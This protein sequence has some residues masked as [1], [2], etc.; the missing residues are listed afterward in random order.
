MSGC[1]R[2]IVAVFAFFLI[3]LAGCGGASP[4]DGFTGDRGQVSGTITLDD[5]P[6]QEGCQVLFLAEQGGYMATGVVGDDG[7]Y[8][9]I[10]A[11]GKGLPVGDYKVQVA[12]PVVVDSSDADTTV[13][14]MEMASQM[15]L[16]PGAQ[17]SEDTGPVPSKYRSTDTSGLSFT[18]EANENTVNINLE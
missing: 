16:A 14:P 2:S 18:V 6:L 10:Y 4:D 11:G 1:S 15:R 13:D 12:P 9:L 3:L 8:T 17:E 5:Q 7:R